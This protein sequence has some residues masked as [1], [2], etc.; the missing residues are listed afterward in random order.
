[1]A[2]S[3]GRHRHRK[4]FSRPKGHSSGGYVCYATQAEVGRH[5]PRSLVLH[6]EWMPGGVWAQDPFWNPTLVARKPLL[7]SE[8]SHQR[9]QSLIRSWQC[10]G[11]GRPDPSIMT[12]AAK[13]THDG[14]QTLGPLS[15]YDPS[16]R[17]AMLRGFASHTQVAFFIAPDQEPSHLISSASFQFPSGGESRRVTIWRSP[18]EVRVGPFGLITSL[19]GPDLQ[20]SCIPLA[21]HRLTNPGSSANKPL[22]SDFVGSSIGARW[23]CGYLRGAMSSGR[24]STSRL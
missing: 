19:L 23:A 6:P 22:S 1:M 7:Q 4:F 18:A 24:F 8:L 5:R 17:L 9:S 20:V 11:S 21:G 13:A 10:C 3:V 15:S 14:C 16:G 2:I 12:L